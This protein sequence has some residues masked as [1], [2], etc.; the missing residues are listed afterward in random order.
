ME[1]TNNT[2]ARLWFLTDG[3]CVFIML[4]LTVETMNKWRF[5]A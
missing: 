1:S 3:L 5:I 4:C 2:K